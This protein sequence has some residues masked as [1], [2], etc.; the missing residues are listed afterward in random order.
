MFNSVFFEE[1]LHFGTDHILRVVTAYFNGISQD[2]KPFS[3]M[4]N[5]C[6][7]GG[8][9]D[10]FHERKTGVIIDHCVKIVFVFYRSGNIHR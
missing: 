2:R 7:I 6:L 1:I 4:T 10:D 5:N 9:C 8:G 3:Q